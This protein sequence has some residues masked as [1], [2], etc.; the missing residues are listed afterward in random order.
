MLFWNQVGRFC[1]HFSALCSWE[2]FYSFWSVGLLQKSI[3]VIC[4]RSAVAFCPFHTNI[5]TSLGIFHFSV[6]LSPLT[7]HNQ[8]QTFLQYFSMSLPKK[9]TGVHVIL[10]PSDT[11]V[12]RMAISFSTTAFINSFSAETLN[13]ISN[14]SDSC[15]QKTFCPLQSSSAFIPFS[16]VC[17]SHVGQRNI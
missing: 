12:S 4:K 8:T 17:L 2:Q 13:T 11:S 5:L 7:P 14:S 1:V 3:Y 6:H 15:A 16:S 10:F 9:G